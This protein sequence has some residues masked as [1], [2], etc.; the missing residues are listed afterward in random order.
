MDKKMDLL[1]PEKMSLFLYFQSLTKESL[2]TP[3]EQLTLLTAL[4]IAS[5]GKKKN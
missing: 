2:D 3:K 4:E 1:N 5:E